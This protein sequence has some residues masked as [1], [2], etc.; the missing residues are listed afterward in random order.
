MHAV[1]CCI[2]SNL[3]IALIAVFLLLHLT[4]LL[5]QKMVKNKQASSSSIKVGE[6]SWSEARCKK[7]PIFSTWKIYVFNFMRFHFIVEYSYWNLRCWWALAPLLM[8][9]GK[10]SHEKTWNCGNRRKSRK[11]TNAAGRESNNFASMRFYWRKVY[12]FL[13]AGVFQVKGLFVPLWWRH[14]IKSKKLAETM[15]GGVLYC[16]IF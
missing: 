8:L 2:S 16:W 14:V 4:F 10:C 9:G 12:R 13:P 15:W 5:N 11:E 7:F 3:L 6:V 1:I